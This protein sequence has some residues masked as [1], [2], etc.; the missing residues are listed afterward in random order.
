MRLT[1]NAHRILS[2]G[3]GLV[4]ITPHRLYLIIQVIYNY[5]TGEIKIIVT[6]LT[7]EQAGRTRIAVT[8]DS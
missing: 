3:A 6:I 4:A 7:R 8:S 5:Q 2:R 1:L